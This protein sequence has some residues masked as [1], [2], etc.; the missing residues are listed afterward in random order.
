MLS[1]PAW[2]PP[3]TPHYPCTAL[4]GPKAQS[5]FRP[6]LLMDLKKHPLGVRG[7][8]IRIWVCSTHLF[9]RTC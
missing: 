3:I 2:G 8:D 4:K 6:K 1:T 9:V 7:K 5:T